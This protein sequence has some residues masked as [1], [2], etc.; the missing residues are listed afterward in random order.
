MIWI[1][2]AL[3][4]RISTSCSSSVLQK[5]LVQRR[6]SS[7]MILAV[8]LSVVAISVVAWFAAS[9]QFTNFPTRQFWLWIAIASILDVAGNLLLVRAI[10]HGD[11][12]VIG[13]LNSY[14]PLVGAALG[15]FVLREFP[16]SWGY[17]GIIII[18]MGSW[19]LLQRR[20]AASH[21]RNWRLNKPVYD[22]LMS[23]VFTAAAS[24]FLKNAIQESNAA[25]AYVG[26]SVGCC[27]LAWIS[28]LFANRPSKPATSLAILKPQS[29]DL[30]LLTASG[31]SFLVMQG[32]TIW[33][34]AKMQIGYALALFQLASIIQV[35][36]GRRFFH[37]D[38]FFRRLVASII[39]TIG[40][41]LVLVGG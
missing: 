24:I 19:I 12:S 20:T 17:A 8:S 7:P 16:T 6:W 21:F 32:T 22:R 31:M 26:W 15:I 35:Y 11:M 37:E 28:L 38:Q 10:G 1:I 3:L 40:A 13:P 23:I 18:V 14:K 41:T 29:S 2:L 39:M 4:A 27:V 25:Q 5:M 36:L 30:Y 33:L 34:F 9:S